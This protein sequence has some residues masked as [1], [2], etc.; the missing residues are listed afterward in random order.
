MS[1]T[2]CNHT[3]GLY[4]NSERKQIEDVKTKEEK[5]LAENSED[6]W[7]FDYCPRCGIDLNF[8]EI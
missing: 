2:I 1:K 7:E 5:T 4:Y 6:Y 8:A 3:F